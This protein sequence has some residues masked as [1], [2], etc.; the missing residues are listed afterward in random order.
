MKLYQMGKGVV[1]HYRNN[2]KGN[3]NASCKLIQRKLTRNILLGKKASSHK[4]SSEKVLYKY[5]C[6]SILTVGN[7]IVWLKNGSN[8]KGWRKDHKRY[9]E[10]NEILGINDLE[11]K[12]TNKEI[13]IHTIFGK[14]K[15]LLHIKSK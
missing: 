4:G 9:N 5:G 14:F 13:K 1:K 7:K 10:L 6:L 11:R 15:H 12:S 3:K 8:P 2:V